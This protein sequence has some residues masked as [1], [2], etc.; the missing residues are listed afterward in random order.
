[1][2]VIFNVWPEKLVNY[3]TF[4]LALRYLAKCHN[5]STLVMPCR[6]LV[7]VVDIVNYLT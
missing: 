5:I 7:S 3:L 1:M 2:E 4:Y 6:S